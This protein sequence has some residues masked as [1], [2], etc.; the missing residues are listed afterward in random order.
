VP[1]DEF[2]RLERR[3]R[4]QPLF[5]ERPKH[6]PFWILIGFVVT[7]A[8]LLGIAVIGP[9]SADQFL[10]DFLNVRAEAPEE[11]EIKTTQSRLGIPLSS[12]SR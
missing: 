8:L 11:Q 2:E 3:W 7:L 4:E 9:P 5:S 1:K 6:R 10:D 12:S